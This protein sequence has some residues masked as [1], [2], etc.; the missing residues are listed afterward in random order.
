MNASDR[1][2]LRARQIID[3]TALSQNQRVTNP[4]ALLKALSESV[5]S[6]DVK[7]DDVLSEISDEA[8]RTAMKAA[9]E[10]QLA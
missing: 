9:I 7:L 10:A 1:A 4:G 2:N 8:V 3:D 5:R 6:G